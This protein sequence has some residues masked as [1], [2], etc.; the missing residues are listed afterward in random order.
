M[1]SLRHKIIDSGKYTGPDH[2]AYRIGYRATE[3]LHITNTLNLWNEN[4]A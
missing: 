3:L 1:S 4:Q 2:L